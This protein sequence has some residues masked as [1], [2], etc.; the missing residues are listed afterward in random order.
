MPLSSRQYYN[1][2]M[3]NAELCKELG[4]YTAF[5]RE[6]APVEK[7]SFE[8]WEAAAAQGC[9]AKLKLTCSRCKTTSE[10]TTLS[11]IQKGNGIACFCS[12]SMPRSSRQYYDTVMDNA[13]LCKELG[14]YT[15]FHRD[16]APAEKPSREVWEAAA[17]QGCY[18][19]L[20]LT[21]SK[22]K[23]TSESTALSSL[24]QGGGIACFC[25][26]SMP[27]SSRQ[28][29]DTIMNNADLCNELGWYT[30]LHRDMAPVETPSFE[31]WEAA[32]VQGKY[33]KLKL[34]C[35]RCK[36]ASAS[37]CL[38]NLRSGQGI[39]CGC[40]N[41]TEG[42]VW[43]PELRKQAADDGHQL[44][45]DT[46]GEY[47]PGHLRTETGNGDLS[48][49]KFDGGLRILPIG[50]PTS[51]ELDGRH[52]FE[53]VCQFDSTAAENQRID[54]AKVRSGLAAGEWNVRYH[55]EG[56]WTDAYQWRTFMRKA[57]AHI[58]AAGCDAAPKVILPEHY[59]PEY[60]Q[61]LEGAGIEQDLVIWL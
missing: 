2:V 26:G 57:H 60:T 12:G 11:D 13:E 17:A 16:V 46:A 42:L 48:R 37:T 44:L 54:G 52:H 9:Y 47:K 32:A 30:A 50:H 58:A 20:K 14:C 49:R 18:A 29:Y 40:V 10:S 23:T 59:R 4:W 34:T 22:C 7:P 36:I 21:C 25:S 8:V 61:W 35:S 53:D 3:D 33:A 27:L 28:Y 19:K 5:H 56:V 6:V 41:K 38:S 15:V 43:F 24:Q 51:G 39:A 45:C 1:T 31:V 55:Q